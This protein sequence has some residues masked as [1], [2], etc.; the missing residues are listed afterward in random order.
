MPGPNEYAMT[1]QDVSERLAELTSLPVQ[2]CREQQSAIVTFAKACGRTPSEIIADAP[3][4]SFL[5]KEANWQRLGITKKSW[6]NVQSRVR[7]ALQLAGVDIA[8]RRNS[9]W[10]PVED[11]VAPLPPRKRQD[12]SRFGGYCTVRQISPHDVTGATFDEFL[13][14]NHEQVVQLDPREKWQTA[15]RAW[16]LLGRTAPELGLPYIPN[17]EPPRWRGL[18]WDELPEQLRRDCRVTRPL[19]VERQPPRGRRG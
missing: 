17:T 4:I 2:R 7:T 18:V 15:R 10:R 8:K 6:A 1:L 5:L 12:L 19:A 14:F 9:S 16:N 3:H 11:L 13:R